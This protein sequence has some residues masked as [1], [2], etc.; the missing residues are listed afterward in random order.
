MRQR[1]VSR[2]AA[3]LLAL[4]LGVGG[5][6]AREAD[7]PPPFE[8]ELEAIR[9]ATLPPDAADPRSEPMRRT[10]HAIVWTWRFET[11]TAWPD[12]VAWL[13]SS[14][15]GGFELRGHDA[16]SAGFSRVL[17]GDLQ[18]LLVQRTAGPGRDRLALTLESRAF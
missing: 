16:S 5:C 14:L 4:A 17:P 12:Y 1:R 7:E 2:R 8:R 9:A 13:E 6:D 11:A 3:A 10:E 18:T 15:P